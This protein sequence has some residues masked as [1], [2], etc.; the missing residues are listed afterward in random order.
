MRSPVSVIPPVVANAVKAE[1]YWFVIGGQAVR[2]F[3][4][5]RPSHD[6]DFGVTKRP[7]VARLLSLLERAGHVDLIERSAGTVHLTFEGVDVSI[8]LLPELAKH[9]EGQALTLTGLL[10]TKAHAILDRG[11]RRDFFDLY[12]LLETQRLGLSDVLRALSAVYEQPIH[13]GLF[14]RAFGYFDDAAA[15][16]PLPGEGKADF[17]LVQAFFTRAVGAL[18][19]P[20]NSG[21][22]IQARQVDASPAPKQKRPSARKASPKRSS[23]KKRSRKT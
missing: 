12:V 9:V 3:V 19:V 21:L 18:V 2:C 8:F 14:L 7:Q 23:A 5:Y 17:K 15:E 16:A 22:Q 20:P 1:D 4:P 13:Q 10:A 11:T 6:V